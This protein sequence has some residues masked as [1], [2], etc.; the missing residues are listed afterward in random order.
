ML[1]YFTFVL[2]LGATT[3][4][5]SAETPAVESRVSNSK[6]CR[7][8]VYEA[9]LRRQIFKEFDPESPIG[10]KNAKQNLHKIPPP[11][12]PLLKVEAFPPFAIAREIGIL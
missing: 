11:E 7:I 1:K 12:P 2:F 5:D 10:G 3:A 8:V 4:R 6:S 9:A